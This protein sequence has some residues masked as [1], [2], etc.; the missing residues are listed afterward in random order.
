[1][2]EINS[3]RSTTNKV[4]IAAIIAVAVILLACICACSVVAIVYL[5][6][7]PCLFC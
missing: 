7:A 1:M 3:E 6:N 2:N 5:F 4:M